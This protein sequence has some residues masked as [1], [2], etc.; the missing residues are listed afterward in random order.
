M[1]GKAEMCEGFLRASTDV[2]GW[3]WEGRGQ[4]EAVPRAELQEGKRG[5]LRT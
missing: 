4:Y 5:G 3:A 2:A 1:Y